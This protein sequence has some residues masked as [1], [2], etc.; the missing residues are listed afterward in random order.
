MAVVRSD[1]ETNAMRGFLFKA[2]GRGTE[3]HRSRI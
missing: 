3:A 1:D 2:K